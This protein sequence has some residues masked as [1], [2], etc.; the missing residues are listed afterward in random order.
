MG[1]FEKDGRVTTEM[2]NHV[3]GPL[4]KMWCCSKSQLAINNDHSLKMA[5]EINDA[6][7]KTTVFILVV[8]TRTSVR[9]CQSQ[10]QHGLQTEPTSRENL[11][12]GVCDQ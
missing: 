5:T 6:M 7:E 1:G 4:D 8:Y 10:D 9:R 12:S 11:S 3:R 2:S